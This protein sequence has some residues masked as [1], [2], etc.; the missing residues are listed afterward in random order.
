VFLRINPLSIP[1][2]KENEKLKRRNQT[3]PSFFLEV[4]WPAQ[5]S[6]S[7]VGKKTHGLVA[8]ATSSLEYFCLFLAWIHIEALSSFQPAPNQWR[9][10]WNKNYP[11]YSARTVPPILSI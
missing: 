11:Y 7:Q 2:E 9:V 1:I 8:K 3:T 6:N 4:Y 5:S 10:K